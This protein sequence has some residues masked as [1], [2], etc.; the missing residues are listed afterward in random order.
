M[1]ARRLKPEVRKAVSSWVWLRR[2]KRRMEAIRQEIGM[3]KGRMK[4]ICS[5]AKKAILSR[6]A[7]DVANLAIS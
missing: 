1:M 3:A 6:E 2:W 7:P 4:G 5:R